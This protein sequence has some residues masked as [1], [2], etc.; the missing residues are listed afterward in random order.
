MFI[1][2]E[3]GLPLP[4]P[5]GPGCPW[6]WIGLFL[7]LNVDFSQGYSLWVPELTRDLLSLETYPRVTSPAHANVTH[8][9]GFTSTGCGVV[10]ASQ[11]LC[12]RCPGAYATD[13]V[14]GIQVITVSQGRAEMSVEVS[15][16][17]ALCR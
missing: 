8:P 6:G 5:H 2:D 1:R 13:S 11:L 14:G 15:I 16:Y 10:W 7:P 4:S 3:S 9:P 17:C 12:P